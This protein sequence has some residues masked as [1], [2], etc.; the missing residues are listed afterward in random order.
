MIRKYIIRNISV[1]WI[2]NTLGQ[3]NIEYF[4]VSSLQIYIYTSVTS[5]S[6]YTWGKCRVSNFTYRFNVN[7]R[8]RYEDT[9]RDCTYFI[10]SNNHYYVLLVM[11]NFLFLLS[12]QYAILYARIDSFRF[13]FTKMFSVPTYIDRI[14]SLVY[15][16]SYK[17]CWYYIIYNEYTYN[18]IYRNTIVGVISKFRNVLNQIR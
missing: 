11:Y 7:F 14:V 4:P 8:C 6:I 13:A 17:R 16:I 1:G 9:Y 2:N 15:L 12:I 18:I 10:F 3:Y 5:S